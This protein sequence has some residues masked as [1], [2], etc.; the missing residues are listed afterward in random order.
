ML[1]SCGE[2]KKSNFFF[3]FFFDNHREKKST[4]LICRFTKHIGSHQ[5]VNLISDKV[6]LVETGPC[7]KND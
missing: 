7:I 6:K 3:F 4:L 2:V 5:Q 1:C